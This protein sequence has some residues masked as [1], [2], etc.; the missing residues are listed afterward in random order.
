MTVGTLSKDKAE[1]RKR[2]KRLRRKFGRPQ[3][4]EALLDHWPDRFADLSVAGYYPLQ[5]EFDVLPLLQTLRFADVRVGLPRMMGKGLPMEFRLWEVGQ[6]L[7]PGPYGVRE[8]AFTAP[9]MRPEIVLVPLLAFDRAGR[10][11]GYGGGYYDRTLAAFPQT[12][13][14]GIAFDEQEVE[15]VPIGKWDRR[16]AGVLTPSGLRM[17]GP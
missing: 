10:R 7:E 3:H 8:P 4:G 2:A 14:I 17:F 6:S 11:L 12:L 16:L 15:K 13:P 1:L 9:V 5:G